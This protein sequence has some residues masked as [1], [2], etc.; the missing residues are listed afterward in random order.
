[1]LAAIIE[2]SDLVCAARWSLGQILS[3]SCHMHM[4]SVG[5]HNP[6]EVTPDVFSLGCKSGGMHLTAYCSVSV[7][8]AK[9]FMSTLLVTFRFN[10]LRQ[11]YLSSMNYV[12][13]NQEWNK[14]KKVDTSLRITR[15][16]NLTAFWNIALFSLGEID[17]S[18]VFTASI[19]RAITL[20]KNESSLLILFKKDGV[21]SARIYRLRK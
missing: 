9:G 10:V 6:T 3:R 21:C 7:Y 5:L 13:W 17:V 8:K 15:P 19:I 12:S 1:M 4:G 11:L 16:T 14:L 18:E 2:T 20:T